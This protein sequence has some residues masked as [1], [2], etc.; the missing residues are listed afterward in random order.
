M[1]KVFVVPHD[2]APH[3][4]EVENKLEALQAIVGGYLE[5]VQGIPGLT[6]LCNE[7]GR[8][9]QLPPNRG[10]LGTWIVVRSEGADFVSLTDED[11]ARLQAGVRS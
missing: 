11:V 4:R 9:M 10:L 2:G 8:M 1:L 6:V 7:D 5:V 3:V